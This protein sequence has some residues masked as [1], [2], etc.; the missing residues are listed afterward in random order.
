MRRNLY[1]G[2]A[3]LLSMG[4]TAIA[5]PVVLTG[6]NVRF[7]LDDAQLT[8]FGGAKPTVQ[9]DTLIFAPPATTYKAEALAPDKAV[10]FKEQYLEF[11]VEAVGG[12]TLKSV[13]LKSA[14]I[15]AAQ[16]QASLTKT[17]A[18]GKLNVKDKLLVN[19]T[20]EFSNVESTVGSW[21][22]LDISIDP[23]GVEAAVGNV[24]SRTLAIS[25]THSLRALALD[26][27]GNAAI[28][29]QEGVS[30]KIVTAEATK[31]D[32]LLDWAESVLPGLG[33]GS[34]TATLTGNEPLQCNKTG[35]NCKD[36]GSLS[37][38]C[39]PAAKQCYG[40]KGDMAYVY[41]FDDSIVRTIGSNKL[42]FD[43]AVKSGF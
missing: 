18:F 9:D 12:Q 30:F 8:A 35:E 17:L 41:N 34:A 23:K 27:T 20:V 38:R 2:A 39:Y 29:N 5:A 19:R 37:Y 24:N 13:A 31:P 40:I 16:G 42:Y 7:I 36:L 25:T 14:G 26:K 11:N 4:H 33:I 3:L 10:G 1:L 32:R 43:Q 21:Q 22:A 15:S 28:N 6:K